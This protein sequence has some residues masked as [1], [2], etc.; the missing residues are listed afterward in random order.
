[1]NKDFGYWFA[2]LCDGEACFSL[3]ALQQHS[4]PTPR[5]DLTLRDDDTPMLEMIRDTLK[6]G[7]IYSRKKSYTNIQGYTSK[8]MVSFIVWNKQDC[9]HLADL[10]HKFP[11]RSKKLRDFEVWAEA[12]NI[13]HSTDFIGWRSRTGTINPHKL[14]AIERLK[15]LATEILRVREYKPHD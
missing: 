8:K 6:F 13:W 14:A 10:L 7:Q 2:G 9:K 1:M 3:R 5:F 4:F 11:L 12:V 15:E